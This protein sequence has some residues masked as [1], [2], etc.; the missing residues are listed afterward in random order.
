MVWLRHQQRTIQYTSAQWEGFPQGNRQ[1]L[2]N[3]YEQ[4]DIPQE[5]Y[6]GFRWQR[7][8]VDRILVTRPLG[9]LAQNK[10]TPLYM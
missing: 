6:C 3:N 1:S 5:K 2:E 7:S 4:E 9:Q 8:K 10:I